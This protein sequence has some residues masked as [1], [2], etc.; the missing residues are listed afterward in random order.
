MPLY[1]N[2]ITRHESKGINSSVSVQQEFS[3]KGIE[4]VVDKYRL[5]RLYEGMRGLLKVYQRFTKKSI[6]KV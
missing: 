6:I 4:L 3:K 2:Y 5:K 1:L